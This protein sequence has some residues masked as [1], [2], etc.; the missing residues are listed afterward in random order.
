MIIL[1]QNAPSWAH[2]FKQQVEIALEALWTRPLPVYTVATKP[3]ATDKK[4]LWRRIALS[5]GASGRPTAVCN[6]TAWIYEDGT[7]V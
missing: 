1:D 7:A 6:G 5:D 3:S 2:R 4:W